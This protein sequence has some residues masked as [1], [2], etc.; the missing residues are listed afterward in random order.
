MIAGVIMCNTCLL[1]LL[2]KCD[3]DCSTVITAWGI[4]D[5]DSAHS[6]TEGDIIRQQQQG[7][8]G[9]VGSH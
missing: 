6:L 9:H 2:P 4:V 7:V 1:F 3:Q 8:G 5:N